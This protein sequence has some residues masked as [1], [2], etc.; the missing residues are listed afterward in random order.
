M[1]KVCN[2][3]INNMGSVMLIK[4]FFRQNVFKIK[5]CILIF[6][7]L[8]RMTSKYVDGHTSSQLTIAFMSLL[9]FQK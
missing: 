3:Y 6:M 4:N 9:G 7:T 8:V 1:H 2:L 5:V